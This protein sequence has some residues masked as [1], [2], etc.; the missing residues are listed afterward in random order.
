MKRLFSLAAALLLMGSLAAQSYSLVKVTEV[1]DGGLYVFERNGRVL[2]DNDNDDR[3]HTTDDYQM[4]S[5]TGKETYVFLLEA[6]GEGYSI[7]NEKRY[8]DN[9]GHIYLNNPSKK[10]SVGFSNEN[11]SKW[12]FTFEGD[13]ALISNEDNENR[14]LGETEEVS[15]AY[16]AYKPTEAN[17]SKYGHDFTVYE[18]QS[19]TAPYITVSSPIVDFGTQAVGGEAVSMD[20]TVSF[21]NLKGQVSLPKLPDDSP[22]SLSGGLGSSS[23]KL[24]ITANPAKEGKYSQT[25]TIASSSA[26]DNV[27]AKVEIRMTV[28]DITGGFEKW[29]EDIKEGDYVITSDENALKASVSAKK[30]FD[31]EVV[32]IAGDVLADPDASVIWHIARVGD[33]WTLYNE[34]TKKYAGSTDTNNQGALLDDAS[35]DN[36]K[37]IVSVNKEENTYDFE[38]V[39]RAAS[40]V[41]PNNKWLRNN[42]NIQD[43]TNYG[44]ACY[45][46]STGKPLT[47]YRLGATPTAV[48]QAE[49]DVKVVKMFENGQVIIIRDGVR[50]NAQ[51]VRLQ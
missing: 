46:S 30:R 38:N 3:I 22:F 18:L 45:S 26:Q 29:T 36:A 28:V 31:Y 47:L 42:N 6:Y 10:T 8:A 32:S 5:L 35:S 17:K 43:G 19:S 34:S 16:R 21:G 39:A 13:V 23:F 4:V 12:V 7:R 9:A 14:F 37:W 41:K 33:Y 25:I 20:I 48:D 51:G 44:F 40:E 2:Y 50:Y 11:T 27:A 1:K 15:D 49:A 24:T